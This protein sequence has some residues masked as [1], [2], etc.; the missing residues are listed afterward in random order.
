MTSNHSVC[1]FGWWSA[2][3][4][5]AVKVN[6]SSTVSINSFPYA[7]QVLSDIPNTN[8]FDDIKCADRV[9]MSGMPYQKNVTLITSFIGDRMI[10][11]IE[12]HW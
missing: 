10:R 9:D 2:H 5:Q 4:D 11:R 3:I 12:I 8:C 7:D 1:P 6:H